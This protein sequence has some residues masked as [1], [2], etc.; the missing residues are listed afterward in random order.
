MDPLF[1]D[2]LPSSGAGGPPANSTANACTSSPARALNAKRE[3][4][5]TARL[6]RH[7]AMSLG[8]DFCAK[9]VDLLKG[10]LGR[11]WNVAW[12]AAGFTRFSISVS[13]ADVPTL[14]MEI[15][16]YLRTNPGRENALLEITAVVA[17]AKLTA[18]EAANAVLNSAIAARKLA[19]V[20]VNDNFMHWQVDF[21]ALVAICQHDGSLGAEL[22]RCLPPEPDDYFVLK[23]KHS[24]FFDTPLAILLAKLGA[25]RLV[26]TGVAADGC[27]LT[28][29]TDAHMREF[30]VHVPRDCVASISPQRTERALALMKDSMKIDVRTARYA[31]A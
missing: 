22:A 25:K 21:S 9:A 30:A 23:P 15:R 10:H 27:V 31:R 14:L 11:T 1:R 24:G 18:A 8:R 12:M 2:S 6:A 5:H 13:R 17:D 26:I 3:T 4:L 29:A 20:Y 19:T 28:T 7:A 16:N